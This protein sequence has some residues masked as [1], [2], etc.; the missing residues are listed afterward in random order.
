M[1]CIDKSV[2]ISYLHSFIHFV[3]WVVLLGEAHQRLTILKNYLMTGIYLHRVYILL[4]E[5]IKCR[6]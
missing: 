6:F 1:G 2:V 4:K 3:N 5:I